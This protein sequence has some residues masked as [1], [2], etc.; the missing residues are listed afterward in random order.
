[1]NPFPQRLFISGAA[2]RSLFRGISHLITVANPGAVQEKP[3]WFQGEH[4]PLWFGDVTSTADARR[5][6]TEAPTLDQIQSAVEFFREAWG[7][8]DSRILV[9]CNY[10]VSRSPALAYLFIADC[11]GAGR[12]AEAFKRMLEIHSIALPNRLVVRLGDAFLGRRG[13]LLPPLKKL[14]AE[15]NEE[16]FPPK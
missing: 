11:L 13:A 5:R 2:E 8:P 1:M 3:D 16:L 4:L 7:R 15:I 14:Y 9:S 10:G 12:E 6:K